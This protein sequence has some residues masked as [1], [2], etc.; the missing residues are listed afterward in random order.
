MI[1]HLA[2]IPQQNRKDITTN[3]S[4]PSQEGSLSLFLGGQGQAYS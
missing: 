2:N 3:H 4:V 1:A